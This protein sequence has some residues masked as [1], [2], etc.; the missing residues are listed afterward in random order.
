MKNIVIFLIGIFSMIFL[1]WLLS[2][3]ETED[4]TLLG[5]YYGESPTF[6]PYGSLAILGILGIIAFFVLR[7]LGERKYFLLCFAA[8]CV[9][10]FKFFS[11]GVNQD[12]GVLLLVIYL[13]LAILHSATFIAIACGNIKIFNNKKAP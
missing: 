10:S 9:Y 12:Y 8:F 3:H 11:Y 1:F 5:E 7:E 2:E 6:T 13:F 4:Y